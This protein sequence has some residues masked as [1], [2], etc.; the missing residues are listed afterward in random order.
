MFALPQLD[1]DV[2]TDEVNRGTRRFRLLVDDSMVIVILPP[3]KD[4]VPADNTE[5]VKLTVAD[6]NN[7]LPRSCSRAN[8]NQAQLRAFSNDGTY[9]IR[10]HPDGLNEKSVGF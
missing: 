1:R 3:G 7:G 9:E 6:T 4:G 5:G 10:W 2:F 8:K